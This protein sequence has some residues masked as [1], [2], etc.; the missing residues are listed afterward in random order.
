MRGLCCS[1]IHPVPLFIASAVHSQA[2]L[3]RPL[4]SRVADRILTLTPPWWGR[5]RFL[6]LVAAAW[7]ILFSTSTDPSRTPR[8]VIDTVI[9]QSPD[10]SWHAA[11]GTSDRPRAVWRANITV[12]SS[13]LWKR[14]EIW[15][16]APYLVRADPM[17]LSVDYWL[18][19]EHAIAA[20]READARG[21]PILQRITGTLP[22]PATPRDILASISTP[23]DASHL[24]NPWLYELGQR[25][26]WLP[27]AFLTLAIAL[28]S[29]R[30]VRR[31]LLERT[32]RI[33]DADFCIHCR[34]NRAGVHPKAPCPECGRDTYPILRQTLD[35]LGMR[36]QA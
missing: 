8:C 2:V 23:G 1:A 36:N 33:I 27:F 13:L 15:H 19:S 16:A 5:A 3:P 21:L 26:R 31:L 28:F 32:V 30:L 18:E 17:V 12:E 7:Y 14:Y 34:Y 20:W 24:V 9:Q 6:L 22:P 11:S 35:A 29:A 10:G 25:T 4:K